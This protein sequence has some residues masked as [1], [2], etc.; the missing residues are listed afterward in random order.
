MAAREGKG[1]EETGP[2]V[3]AANLHSAKSGGQRVEREIEGGVAR[4][5][6]VPFLRQCSRRF[7][8][9]E[10][11]RER[12]RPCSIYTYIRETY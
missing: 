3:R 1:R 4:G 9:R 8:A 10:R 11:Q 7:K 6:H 5:P 12:E 2:L